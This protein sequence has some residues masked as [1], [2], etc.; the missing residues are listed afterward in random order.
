MIQRGFKSLNKTFESETFSPMV[1][2]PFH[3]TARIKVLNLFLIL[4]PETKADRIIRDS[5]FLIIYLF[6]T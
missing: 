6:L 3:T 2:V 5:L 4:V 1:L